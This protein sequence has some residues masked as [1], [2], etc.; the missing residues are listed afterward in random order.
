MATRQ[1]NKRKGTSWKGSLKPSRCICG[2]VRC[3]SRL[4]RASL[5]VQP[6]R[7]AYA[8]TSGTSSSARPMQA[9][10]ARSTELERSS[11]NS[12][13]G[14]VPATSALSG[15]RRLPSVPSQ[16][17]G[18]AGRLLESATGVLDAR[19][20]KS[21]PSTRTMKRVC[22]VSTRGGSAQDLHPRRKRT[23]IS[24]SCAQTASSES[25]ATAGCW[26]RTSS[27]RLKGVLLAGPSPNVMA[28]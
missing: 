22:A 14:F 8:P 27:L 17:A 16:I 1:G 12:G 11:W 10:P 25:S 18:S 3:G 13:S 19:G 9:Q 24:P 5:A 2:F 15:G 28:V 26:T 23:R 6:R 7:S 21:Q 20:V 4:R